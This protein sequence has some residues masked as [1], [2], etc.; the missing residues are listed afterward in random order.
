MEGNALKD[1]APLL[2]RGA[3]LARKVSG[4]ALACCCALL[5]LLGGCSCG[6]KTD[7]AAL[8]RDALARSRETATLRAYLQASAQSE[9]GSGLPSLSV[10]GTVELDRDMRALRLQFD[11]FMLQGELRLVGEE[12]Y[13]E[14]GGTWYT[15]PAGRGSE[16]LYGLVR[17]LADAVFS[18]PDIVADYTEV[19]RVGDEK[20]TGRDCHRLEVSPDL[21]ALASLEPI[22]EMGGS[23][24][25]PDARLLAELQDMA[26][27]LQVWV[28][29]K[30]GFI[31][32][33]ELEIEADLSQ[34]AVFLGLLRGR[35]ALQ[36]TAYFEDYGLPL[37]IEPPAETEPLDPGSIPFL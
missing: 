15:L 6:G 20:V 16:D 8:L 31:R 14:M 4:C 34:G 32:K 19:K 5:V 23:L 25:V 10:D 1:M 27:A 3:S 17:G 13:L 28:D 2:I 24:G 33:M 21:Q 9:D 11:S 37:E 18:Y 22:R 30:D 36:V 7:A 26:P 12:L 35:M 29:K